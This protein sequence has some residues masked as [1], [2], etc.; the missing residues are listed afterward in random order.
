[1][2]IKDIKVLKNM[3]TNEF[4]KIVLLVSCMH[5]TDKSILNRLNIQSRFVI[6]NQCDSDL[7]EECIYVASN[8]EKYSGLFIN[9]TERGLSKSRNM[10]ISYAPADSICV[11]CDD[12][13]VLADNYPVIIN[14]AYDKL[15]QVDIIAFNIKYSS[16]RYAYKKPY[17]KSARLHFKDLLRVSSFQITFKAQKVLSNQIKFDIKMG[18]GTG[19]GGGEE[20]KFLLD[21]RKNGLSIWCNP[22]E[23]ASINNGESQWFKGFDEKYFKDSFWAARRILGTPIGLFY[24]FYWCLFRSN[25]F[26]VNISK[27]DMLK[28]SLKGF[29][30]KR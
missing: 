17:K 27:F 6:V 29:F 3:N 16:E 13:E 23:L 24:L 8:G 22:E 19:N 1:M 30:E 2:I 21:C 5:Q 11:I 25:Y 14:N 12:D 28:Y 4:E 15:P 20:N 18:S 26:D 7:V 9:T 10:A